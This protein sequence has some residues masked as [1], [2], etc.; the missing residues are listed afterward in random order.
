LD[1]VTL[2]GFSAEISGGR[3]EGRSITIAITGEACTG[4]IIK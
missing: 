4:I 1:S 3:K 2:V